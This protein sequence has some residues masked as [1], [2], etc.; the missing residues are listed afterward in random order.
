MRDTPA[1]IKG[2]F[3]NNPRILL[4]DEQTKGNTQGGRSRCTG[5]K[6]GEGEACKERTYEA[7]EDAA[8]ARHH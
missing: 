4:E 8:G 5:I 2:T 1:I 3:Q 6:K 7:I